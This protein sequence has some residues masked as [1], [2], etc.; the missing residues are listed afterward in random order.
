[1]PF[2]RGTPKPPGSGRKKGS[3]TRISIE[4]AARLESLGCDPIE[5]M[6]IIAMDK[7]YPPELRGRMFAELAQYVHPKLRATDH[8]LVDAEGNDRSLLSEFDRLVESA[9]TAEQ[10]Q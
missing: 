1:M 3:R 6:A 2:A 7:L 4:I 10:A 5:G 8:R 9:E